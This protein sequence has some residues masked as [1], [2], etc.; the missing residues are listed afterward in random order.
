MA[1]LLRQ[2]PAPEAPEVLVSDMKELELTP[3]QGEHQLLST[4]DSIAPS[5]TIH[6]DGRGAKFPAVPGDT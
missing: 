5:Y 1:S 6:T 2:R 3:G 4:E